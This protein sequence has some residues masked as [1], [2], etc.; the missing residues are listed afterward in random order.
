MELM[1]A[2]QLNNTDQPVY[3][4]HDG[5]YLIRGT[6]YCRPLEKDDQNQFCFCG[7]GDMIETFETNSGSITLCHRH[8]NDPEAAAKKYLEDMKILQDYNKQ[9]TL[10]FE[11]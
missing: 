4:Y 10:N 11:Q 5:F 6:E 3:D 1:K 8:W 2:G 9:L 7:W